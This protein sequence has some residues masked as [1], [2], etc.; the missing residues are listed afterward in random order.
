MAPLRLLIAAFM[1]AAIVNVVD[2]IGAEMRP[3]K[4]PFAPTPDNAAALSDKAVEVVRQVDGFSL[5]YSQE[6]IK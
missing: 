2:A 6:M 1:A 4:L 3:L 5:D